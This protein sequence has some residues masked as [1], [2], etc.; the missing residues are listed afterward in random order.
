MKTT[1]AQRRRA[2]E[3]LSHAVTHLLRTRKY[4]TCDRAIAILSQ[5]ERCQRA[6]FHMK[7]RYEQFGFDTPLWD[8]SGPLYPPDTIEVL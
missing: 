8:N 2:T 7:I 5:A 6:G 4:G 1:A 3:V